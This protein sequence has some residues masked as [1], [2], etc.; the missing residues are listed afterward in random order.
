MPASPSDAAADGRYG[1]VT[2]QPGMLFTQEHQPGSGIDIL[3]VVVD[4]PAP[5]DPTAMRTAWQHATAR[6]PV[7][8]TAFVWPGGGEP[9][10]EVRAQASLPVAHHDWSAQPPAGRAERLA[11]FLADDR[12]AGFDSSTAP[13]A[14]VTLVTHGP[15]RHTLAV[16]LHHAI[17]DGRS[18]HM[19]L[20]EVCAEHDALVAGRPYAAVRRPPFR[21]YAVWAAGRPLDADQRFWSARL[22]G[23][24]LPTPLPLTG[25]PDAPPHGV[26]SVREA[27]RSLDAGATAALVAAARTVGVSL[28]TLVTAAWSVLLHRYAGVTDVVFGSTRTCRQDTVDGAERMLGLLINTVPVRIRVEPD[29]PVRDWLRGVRRQ[30]DE[31]RPHQLAP[32]GEIQRWSGVPASSPLF[33]SL[34]MYEHQ[35]LQTA[36]S[37]SVP[38]WGDRVARVHRHPG[39]PV[40][41]CVYGEPT[42]T[43]L[44]YHDRRRLTEAG[45]DAMLRHFLVVLTGLAA[46]TARPVSALPLLDTTDRALLAGF[47]T[48]AD[49][50]GAVDATVPEL[51]TAVARRQPDAVA[52]VGADGTTLRY[53]ELEERA[54]RLAGRLVAA[55]V[56]PDEPVAVALPRSVELV[57]A[58]LAVL[59]AG[60]A[61]LPLDPDDP[62]ARIRQLLAVAG[63]PLV[64]ATGGVPGA[65]RLLRLDEPV[66]VDEPTAVGRPDA[67]PAGRVHPAGLAYVSFT[68]GSTGT[69]KGVAV[70]HAAVVRLVHRPGYLRLGPD[71][72]VLHLA[73][74]AFDAATLEIWG[75]LANGAR[76]V[77]APAGA[78]DL[79]EL[80]RLLRRERI[81]VLWLTAGLFHQLVEFDPE[82]LAAVG[83]L[84]AG[85]DVLAPEAVRRAL[86]VRGGAP[87]V[88]GYGPTE[89]TTFTCVHPMT[90]PEAV[91]D[92]V[93][94]GRPVPRSTVYVLDPQGRQVPVGVPGELHTG[95]AGLARGYLNRPA[96]TAA[97]FVPDP[98]DPRPGAR[99]YR[100][101]D[102]VRWR[103]DGTLDFLG[104]I[105]GQVK[106][107]GFRVEP[108]EVA[109]ALRAHPDVGDAV[110][111]VDGEGERRRLLAYLTPRP[112]RDAPRPED[113][114]RYAAERLPTHL[115]PAAHL[116]LPAL[117]LT[118]NGKI[119]RRALPLPEPPPDR[120][121]ADLT[122][123]VHLR[124]AEVWAGL[125]GTAPARVDDD[126]F[127]LGG[128]SL[129]ATRLTFVVADRFGVDLPVRLVYERP[130]LA[131]LAEAIADRAS[132]VRAASTGVVRRDRSGY[133]SA[134]GPSVPVT[135]AVA[136]PPVP[137]APVAAPSA[138]V[139]APSASVPAVSPAPVAVPP[140]S[141][142]AGGPAHLVRPVE[143]P[144]ALWR[145]VGLRAAGFPVET[146]TALG[147]PDLVRAADTLLAAE[148]RLTATRRELAERVHRVR[149]ASPAGERT[150]WNRAVRQLRRDTPPE[151]LPAGSA[152]V[153][154]GALVRAHA[155]LCAAHADRDGAFVA[156]RAAYDRA[157]AARAA[158]LRAT[159]AD[160]L[161]R[162][163]VTWQNRHALRTGVDPVL[164]AGDRRDSRHRQ[165]EALVATYLQRYCVKN[166]TIGFF[167]PVGWARITD[168]PPGLAV[169]HGGAPLARRTVYLENWAVVEVAEALAAR[170]PGLRP[171][172]VP[173][174]MPFLA[175]VGDELRMPLTP[176][177]GLPPVTARL[178][179]A[180][181]GTRSAGEIAAEL[182]ADPTTG[183]AT[184]EQV[185]RMLAELREE[186]RI[187]WSL[188]VPKED[189]FPERALRTRLTAIGDA[190]V[191]EPALAALDD[192]ERARDEVAAAAGDA[193]R[194]GAAIEALEERFRALTGTA[195]TRR[196]GR[197]Y[198]GRTLVYEDCRSGTEVTLS[199]D[200]VATCWPALSLLLESVRW[201]TSAGAALFRRAFVERYRELVA[202]TG[203]ATVS[204][205]DFWLWANDLLFD[206]PEKLVAPVVRALQDRWARVLPDAV[207]HRVTATSTDLRERVAEAFAAPRPG[208]VGAYQHSPD[209]LLAAD[210]PEAVA[211]GDFHWVVGEV[212]PGVNTLRSALFVAQH[213]AP[214]ELRAAMAADL[215]YGRL[216][217]AATGEEGGASSRLTDKL[218]TDRDLR[219]VFGHDSCGLDPATS[220]PVA[221]CLLGPVD[222]VLTVHSRDGRH[223][224][225]LTEVLGEALMVQLVQR[226]DIRRPADHQPRITV[227]RVVLARE[228]WRFTA[229]GLDFAGLPDEGERFHRVRRW[230]RE[231]ALPRHVF[232]KTPAEEKPFHLDFASLAAVDVFARAV[233]RVG[234]DRD[235]AVRLT[236]MLPGP[237]QTWLTDA[238]GRH[239][240][241]ELRLV[242]VDTRVPD[243]VEPT[244]TVPGTPTA[245]RRS[246]RPH[247]TQAGV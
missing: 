126:F 27:S 206:P 100:T 162:E 108:G 246:G 21:D 138:P 165:H 198:A 120:P 221:D 167:G 239:R 72:T 192:L 37:R 22:T 96:A 176:P 238:Q 84:L 139:A 26:S 193:D 87:L 197:T 55:G 195:P 57:V 71:E 46:G 6:H 175:V 89:N 171:W 88:N 106:I 190:A 32:L 111:V 148:D 182:A 129:L 146:L 107:R 79:A 117:P 173:R 147:D 118:R 61:Y 115:R 7:L 91:P 14:R 15:D 130:T 38:G 112:G 95:G 209:V 226:F 62:P 186:R 218:V 66:D 104:R 119:D 168:A 134:P 74:V 242:A 127:V 8:R 51:V 247:R 222:G 174:R 113:L 13:L 161:F 4:W 208:W 194:L 99:M 180:C 103:P 47:R 184:G 1:T 105:D 97:A 170:D 151:P 81:S 54:D 25:G 142:R 160:P 123:P 172:L 201:F 77:V 145:W 10:Q 125:L 227:D 48:T 40:T 210:G 2:L 42:L 131:A 30:V 94:I 67:V 64:L 36:L 156:Y 98:F 179:R 56:R 228:S 17:L 20:D 58:L 102:L 230:Q 69:P 240:T 232:V 110:V 45:A 44:L 135:P 224:L 19:L 205:A 114:S 92:P 150:G 136:V 122:D 233:R 202:R 34:L 3:Q 137:S 52:L 85:G 217:L 191:R 82:C 9:A 207:D 23:V 33:D 141:I 244:S 41:V 153:D 169:H 128:N 204:F 199:T 86:R 211:R 223:R 219:L 35:D 43:V 140:A 65:T 16:T 235:A 155:A 143:G 18:V 234:H 24:P 31:V 245:D 116:V 63:D 200:L 70:P 213:P 28:G 76:L 39:P 154:G 101:G 231:H 164:T 166:D 229:A 90:D 149:A 203:T 124:L 216:T 159:A 49:P 80:A 144:W 83:Q 237:E 75:A 59:K 220:L 188:E 158:A 178:L 243:P 68:S 60:G 50:A 121:P 133:R 132:G 73:P 53:R 11:R 163:A 152:S 214:E 183:I 185:Y 12:A 93:P 215:P 196:A 5:L 212:H 177:V 189:V 78:P 29:Q 157:G 241:A 236:E 109:A 181:D 187:S 225:P